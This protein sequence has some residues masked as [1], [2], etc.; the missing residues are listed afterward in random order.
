MARGLKELLGFGSQRYAVIDVGTNSVKFHVGERAADGAW[1]DDRRPGRGHAPRRGT[2]RARAAR[3]GADGADDR[4]DRRHGRRGAADRRR[5]AIAAVGTAGL[6]IAANTRRFVD[7]VRGRAGRRDR[8][9]LG[10]GREPA[11]LPRGEGGHRARPTG[12][13]SCSTRAAAAPSS[14]S[15]TANTS[16]SGSASTSAPSASPSASGSTVPS[17][18]RSL[19]AALDA[20]AAD[21]A[22]LDGRPRPG[23]A[24]RHGRRVTN[25]AA[26]KHGLATYDP[27]VVQGTVLDRAEVDRQIELYRIRTADERRADRR[28]AARSAPRSSSPAPASCG[29][30]WRSSAATRST[31][32]DRGLR[33][34]LLIDAVRTC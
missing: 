14:R 3:A 32:S 11:R 31:V 6:R 8:G 22:R 34:G 7:A 29:P 25:L 1:R 5:C 30:C 15:A 28:P 9:H 23:R 2:R 19:A 13:S 20:I 12:R 26:V 16:T 21:L 33:H 18:T 24:R 10:R 4:G 27:D 17:P